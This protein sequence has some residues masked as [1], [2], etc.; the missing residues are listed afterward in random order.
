MELFAGAAAFFRGAGH[1]LSNPGLW[2][3]A[4]A[5]FA[6]NV[7]VFTAAAWL[8][9]ANYGPVV[10]ELTPDALG[11]VGEVVVG[12]LLGSLAVA[13]ALFG[14][15]IVGNAIAGPFMDLMTQRILSG[16]GEAP[17]PGRPVWLMILVSVGRQA[18]KLAFFLGLQA[19]ASALWL[20]PGAGAVA[21]AGA[22]LLLL[23]WFLGLEYLD[24]PLDARGL[25]IAA[26]YGYAARN[27]GATLGFGAMVA[28]ISLVPLLGCFC[29][30]V[31]VSGAALL[32][33]RLGPR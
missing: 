29:I 14:Y 23:L 26:R 11:A 2:G 32:A 13:A 27:L 10:D 18:Q 3:Y 31:S 9:V 33:H 22:A 8:F 28:L 1:L 30:P 25:S 20:I 21:H 4:L 16:L 15:T 7:A 19:C 24:Y 17:P 5:A 12:I 6:V